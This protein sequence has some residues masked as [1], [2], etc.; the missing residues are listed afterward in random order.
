VLLQFCQK[1]LPTNPNH[2]RNR[3][4]YQEYQGMEIRP[5]YCQQNCNSH[6][7][8][9]TLTKANEQ[10]GTKREVDDLVIRRD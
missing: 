7:M 2:Y 5:W 8:Q 1:I 6:L 9:E 10:S 4:K 3:K